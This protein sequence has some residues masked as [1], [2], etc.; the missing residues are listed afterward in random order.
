MC[1]TGKGLSTFQSFIKRNFDIFGSFFGL[2]FV[3]WIILPAWIL[4]SIESK[5]N[6][7]FTQHRIGLNGRKFRVI[8]IRTMIVSKEIGTTVTVT[9]DHR[10]TTLGKIWRKTK[11]DELPQLFNVLVGQMSFVGPRP[12]VEGFADDL[13]GC[14][15]IVLSIRPGI[16]GP[17]TLKYRNEELL[18]GSQADPEK[19][20]KEIVWPDKVRINRNYVMNWSFKQDLKYIWMTI[21]R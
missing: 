14:D 3:T 21:F 2:L 15:R 13:T 11:I 16:T 17:A 1:F 10:I 7:F 5:R 4:S 6:G 18:L 12:D 19:Y 9:G 20:N 8:K